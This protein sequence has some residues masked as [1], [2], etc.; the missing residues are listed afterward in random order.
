MT[1]DLVKFCISTLNDF[2]KTSSMLE[3]RESGQHKEKES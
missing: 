1:M 2:V 3:K